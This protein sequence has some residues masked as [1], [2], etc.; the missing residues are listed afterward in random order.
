MR[1]TDNV[2]FDVGLSGFVSLGT[3][4]NAGDPLAIVHARTEDRAGRALQTVAQAIIISD[5]A[6]PVVRLVHELN[7]A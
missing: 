5:S 2:D 3:F 7:D 1:A 4:V 6:P